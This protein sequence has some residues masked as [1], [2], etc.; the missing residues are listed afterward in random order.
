MGENCFGEAE[1]SP[2][3]RRQS[4]KTT[5]LRNISYKIYAFKHFNAETLRKDNVLILLL[6]VKFVS[7]CV[8]PSQKIVCLFQAVELEYLYCR[9]R[10]QREIDEW[11]ADFLQVSD[12]GVVAEIATAPGNN[13]KIA[14]D[15]F[16]ARFWFREG[17]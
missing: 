17:K 4:R 3:I 16:L 9:H 6:C 12:V 8:S 13:D 10:P 7:F 1:P 2:H 5:R 15:E 11:L 14:A